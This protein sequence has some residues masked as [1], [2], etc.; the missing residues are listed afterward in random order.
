MTTPRETKIDLRRQ[1]KALYAPPSTPVLVEV[2]ELA[3]LMVDGR[4]DPNTSEAYAEAIAALYAV[5]YAL[6]FAAKRAP[7]GI[8]FTV[9]PLE[10]LWWA[11]DMA[12]FSLER[13][14]AWQWTMMIAQPDT[15]TP[16]G[17]AQAVAHVARKKS[18]PAAARLRLERV[19]EGLCAQTLH[20]GPY[21]AEGATIATLHAFIRDGGYE[22]DGRRQKHHEIY[23]ND[24]KRTVPE[25]LKTVIRQPFTRRARS[26]SGAAPTDS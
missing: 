5:S 9:M 13:K 2:P 8:D 23:L 22:F 4:G 12:E 15:V 16:E 25:K 1:L 18:L 11:D 6:K 10:G 20:V 21:N 14:A 3:F 19:E 17:V 24:P 7:N 26:V